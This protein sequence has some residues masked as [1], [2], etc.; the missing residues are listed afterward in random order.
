MSGKA[1]LT[2]RHP[3]PEPEPTPEPNLLLAAFGFFFALPI[4]L[5]VAV[6]CFPV[7]AIQHFVLLMR[8]INSID[9]TAKPSP[10]GEWEREAA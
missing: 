10:P 5:L 7:L 2:H 8:A 6:V 4:A 3:T 9:L 1:R